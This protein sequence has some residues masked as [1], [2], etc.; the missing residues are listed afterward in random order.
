MRQER[1]KLSSSSRQRSALQTVEHPD[2][3]GFRVR[4]VSGEP[5]RHP[6]LGLLPVDA[7]GFCRVTITKLTGLVELVRFWDCPVTFCPPGNTED[8]AFWCLE[9]EDGLRPPT[10]RY[11]DSEDE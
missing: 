3:H 1:V 7:E 5:V 6:T 9:L 2:G 4:C 11:E 8:T 10:P